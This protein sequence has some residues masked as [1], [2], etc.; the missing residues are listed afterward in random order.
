[1]DRVIDLS[2][3]IASIQ[4]SISL[5]KVLE[6]NGKWAKSPLLAGWER[7]PYGFSAEAITRLCEGLQ[8][9]RERAIAKYLQRKRAGNRKDPTREQLELTGVRYEWGK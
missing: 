6:P 3:V 2:G 7:S 1:M 8:S 5:L 4:C 9:E